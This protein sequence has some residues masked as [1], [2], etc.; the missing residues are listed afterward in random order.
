MGI[1]SILR[2]SGSHIIH[3]FF[4]I[5]DIFRL[6]GILKNHS[7]TNNQK[8]YTALFRIKNAITIVIETVIA[9][10]ILYIKVS[11]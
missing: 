10:S 8:S 11:D 5:D 9:F 6:I 4:E 3:I 7:L 2:H 1:F